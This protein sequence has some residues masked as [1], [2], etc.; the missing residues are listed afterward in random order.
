MPVV[1]HKPA[2]AS[3]NGNEHGNDNKHDNGKQNGSGN[4]RDPANAVQSELIRS[5]IT[6]RC[7]KCHGEQKPKGDLNLAALASP[8]QLRAQPDVVQRM[9]EAIDSQD[10]PPE[11]EPAL[12][13][14][15]RPKLLTA[16][17]ALL[18]DAVARQPHS[19]WPVRR[20]NRWQYN[21]SVRDL[22]LLNR[23]LF[24]LP[25]KLMT[26]HDA[27][28]RDALQRADT[29]KAGEFQ[30]PAKLRV[31]SQTLAPA[32]G[33]QGLKPFPKDLRAE[34]GFD[35]QANQLS[36][37]PLLLDQ[38]LRLSVSLVDSPDFNPQNV[39]QWA[40]WFAAPPAAAD[41]TA[42]V[43]RRVRSMARRAFRGSIDDETVTRYSN[44]A[45]AKIQAGMSFPDSMKRVLSAL[46]SS[47][48]FLYRIPATDESTA[49]VELAS[50]LSF[51]L[52]SSGPDEELLQLAERGELNRP[53]VRSRTIDRM[54]RDPKI[55][56]FL[57]SFPAQWLQ[58]ENTLAAT[59]DPGINRYFSLIGDQPASLQMVVEPLLL[60]D[61]MF[62][63]N[64]PLAQLVQ[65][66]FA[67]RSEFL[68][69]WY[70]S[71]LKP[72]M[73]DGIAVQA[74]NQ[75]RDEQRNL[76][77]K[78]VAVTQRELDALL[79]PLR[80]QL[81]AQKKAATAN[82]S[83]TDLK[84]IAA[85]EFDEDLQDRVGKLHLK[86]HG[87]VELKDGTAR[88]QQSFLQSAPL[89]FELKAKT[90]EVVC[91]VHQLEERGGGV[92][93]VQGPGDFFDTIV[94]GERKPKHWISG[95]N[96]FARTDDFG[97][98]TA[99]TKQGQWIHLA[100]VYT[101][102]GTTTLYR[103][104]EIYGKPF[105]RGLA[106]FP[107]E[108]TSIL[109][110]LRHL[111]AG[112]NKFLSIT[113]DHA[114]LYDRALS[115]EEVRAAPAGQSFVITEAELRQAM[116]VDQ[117]GRY[118]QLRTALEKD[119]GSLQAI[120]ANRDAAKE[121]QQA[122]QQFDD[123]LRRLMRMNEFTRM[124]VTD[125]RFGGVITNAAMATM[126][127]GP[128]RTHPIARGAWIIGVIFNDPPPPPPNDIPPL[129]EDQGPQE[130]TIREKFAAHRANPSCAGCHQR[131]DPL[132]FAMENFDITGRWRAKYE[133]GKPVDAS[134]S[135]LR[136]YPFQDVTEFKAAIVREDERFA[137]AFAAHLLRYAL[138]RN[139]TPADS[140][141]VEAIVTANKPSHYA[142]RDLVRAVSEQ[143]P[144][145]KPE[146]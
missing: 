56:R 10:M 118:D 75:R 101:A 76:L 37:S 137:R 19:N 6:A 123:E 14:V 138:A 105:N 94:L 5:T 49:Q 17:K 15:E 109:F 110:G 144:L 130:Q 8:E 38:F 89:T 103:D 78:A 134:G 20:L 13:A 28:L 71:D 61:A 55:E 131:I 50:N 114:R 90:L 121:Q 145:T 126:N 66:P 35:N 40:E 69:R 16:L 25:E 86:A 44:F 60:F 106:T 77:Q 133:N 47:P 120:P 92:M 98:S 33:F 139:L 24:E 22:L 91:Q 42:E 12:D 95:S 125:A 112:G 136:Q 18:R 85:W 29:A 122:V 128:K 68:Q 79:N 87:K 108:Q 52:W 111:P 36:L 70:F 4:E 142:I 82:S 43:Q 45:L 63:E 81:L 2:Q 48:S 93:G 32:P 46:L 107:A 74:E 21:Y 127:S 119:K 80:Q 115:V 54:L 41:L 99:E 141:S 129:N 59:P 132:G 58:L 27:Y 62:L 3:E 100:M 30:L 64:R 1:V 143:I 135:L 73:V 116:S 67:Y 51:F 97:D 88:L 124:P 65:P 23:D 39:G 53:E 140:L 102:D 83:V 113:L 9:I 26:R 72:P 31:S 117:R 7:A 34:H 84:P 104:G 57:D 11:S 96:G 146:K